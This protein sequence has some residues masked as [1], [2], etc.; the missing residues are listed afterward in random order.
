MLFTQLTFT[1]STSAIE[2]P[3]KGVEYVQCDSNSSSAYL[4]GKFILVKNLKKIIILI[5][6]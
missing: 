2:T 5:Q 3:E 4:L 1:C 6:N